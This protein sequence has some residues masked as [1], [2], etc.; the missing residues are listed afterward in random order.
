M[1]RFNARDMK[2]SGFIRDRRKAIERARARAPTERKQRRAF[3][4]LDHNLSKRYPVT[5]F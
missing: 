3:R 4:Y 2:S 5:R 1:A